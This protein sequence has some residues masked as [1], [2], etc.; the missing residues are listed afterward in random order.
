MRRI[1]TL[2]QA[3]CLVLPLTSGPVAFAQD[4]SPARSAKSRPTKRS[5]VPRPRARRQNKVDPA[6][7]FEN[8]HGQRSARPR[9]L[10]ASDLQPGD[11]EVELVTEDAQLKAN[12]DVTLH[13]KKMS[14]AE[15][16]S[17]STTS[18]KTDA[19]G[20]VGF[21]GLQPETDYVYHVE[22]ENNGAHYLSPE[23]QFRAGRG[24]VRVQ[25]PVFSAT[26]E[27]GELVVLS[28]GLLALSPQDDKFVVRVFWRIENYSKRA[29]VP[30]DAIIPLP[31]GFKALQFSETGDEPRFQATGD[32]A[33]ELAGTFTP[34]RH[35]L[36]FLF[37]LPTHGTDTLNLA[38]P[39]SFNLG[40]LR[41]LL[42]TGPNMQLKVA[43]F[44]DPEQQLNRKGQAMLIASRDFMAEK[45]QPPDEIQVTVTGIPTPP[46]GRNA[47][48]A[49]AAVI[50]LFGL[51][52]GLLG[53]R[54]GRQSRTRLSP[55]DIARGSELIL[56]ELVEVEKARERGEIGRKMHERTRRQLL[57]AYARLRA[58]SS[59]S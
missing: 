48:V 20:F 29:W 27:L 52:Q 53:R 45:A 9:I 46:G 47:A 23:F 18:A 31:P 44:P 49:L 16:N 1:R 36:Q 56:E 41:V 32:G 26:S 15:G 7:A 51:G 5:Q 14:I 42:E 57:E 38:W 54:S 33:V 58:E 34:G 25:L 2:L 6:T 10:G 12:Q 24:G 11:L 59:P 30:K 39:A 22:Y 50:A 8:P 19:Q 4:G 3:A 55:A 43:G 37:H 13:I 35:D 17:E 28:R 40:S 21:S